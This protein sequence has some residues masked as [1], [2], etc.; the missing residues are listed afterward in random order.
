MKKIQLAFCTFAVALASV[1]SNAQNTWSPRAPMLV[2]VD[3]SASCVFNNQLY[4]FGGEYQAFGHLTSAG[5]SYDSSANAW[6]LLPP[7]PQVIAESGAATCQG[8]IYVV[9]GLAASGNNVTTVSIF[10][11]VSGAWSTGAPMPIAAAE[12]VCV[13]VNGQIYCIGNYV[14]GGPPDFNPTGGEVQI[15]DPTT[16]SWSIGPLM[17]TPRY[18]ACGVAVGSSIY[19]FGGTT[20]TVQNGA[21]LAIVE[22]LDTTT[23][24]WS[25]KSSL[26]VGETFGACAL[27]GGNIYVLGG[28][29]SD[30]APAVS[31]IVQIYDPQQDSWSIGQPLPLLL[32]T[33]QAGAVSSTGTTPDTIIIAG[34]YT[35]GTQPDGETLA[36][37][38]PLSPAT[39]TVTPNAVSTTYDGA[40][41]GNA[42]YSD[43]TG[44]YT[45]TGFQNGDTISSAGV[46]LSGSMAFN[47]STSTTVENVGSYALTAGTLT[48]SSANGNYVM[49]FSNP[50]GNAYVITPATLTVTANSL[51]KTYGSADPTLTYSVSGLQG[52][53]AASTVLMGSLART[54]GEDV[55][56]YA[57]NQGTLA[58]TP[59]ASTGSAETFYVANYYNNTIV[60]FDSAGNASLFASS[61]LNGPTGLAFDAQGNLYVA[62]YNQD[63]IEKFS[64]TGAD[65]GVFA[66]TLCCGAYGLAFDGLGNLYAGIYEGQGG[67]GIERFDSSGNA[68][69]FA[70]IEFPQGLA[71]DTQGNLYVANHVQNTIEKFSSTGVDLGAFAAAGMDGPEALAFDGRGNLYVANFDGDT[72]EKFDSA[73]NASLF[74]SSGLDSPI[75]LAFD[76]S[77]NLYVVNRDSDTIEKFSPTGTDLGVFAST[78][79]DG[80]YFIAI[81]QGALGGNANYAINFVPGTLT[82]TEVPLT[83][84][85]PANIV[86][87]TGGACSTANLPALNIGTP[88][89]T[90]NIPDVT[91]T[92]SRSDGQSLTAAYPVGIT[93][94]TW[95]VTDVDDGGY[96]ATYNQTVEVTDDSSISGNFNGTRIPEGSTIWFTAVLTPRLPRNVTAPVTIW[97]FAQNITSSAF[98]LAVPNATVVFDPAATSASANCDS[99]GRWTTRAPWSGLAGNT[100]LAT[101]AYQL[102]PG[103]PLPGGLQPVK[104][105]GTFATDTPGVT[106]QWQWSAAVYSRFG[107][108]SNA[109]VK[110]T[111]DPFGDWNYKNSDCAGTP[112]NYKLYVIGGGQGGGGLNCTGSL[113]SAKAVVPC[114]EQSAP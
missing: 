66:S 35:P 92:P 34:G 15:Y 97:F 101:Y 75:G 65:L 5:E 31:S 90:P 37:T 24:T 69:D 6:S 114:V 95:T 10:D 27:V 47:G 23:M 57:I 79:L 73:G 83:I 21:P 86:I 109:G 58:V 22:A 43:N 107:N 52:S 62:N 40:A 80:P 29:T 28:Q 8:K 89:W 42:N 33:F 3:F 17:L 103:Q 11:P 12:Y 25:T 9:G 18:G 44:N 55:G 1:N 91:V 99:S 48:L 4:V 104:W 85:W 110:C 77:G 64:P 113:G 98:N 38:V 20:P 7:L 61:G 70:T 72:V 39:L 74:A 105:D 108:C 45:I 112:E 84:T 59:N 100:L 32:S 26:P 94:I 60:T 102:P 88:T 111:D 87:S 68:S 2:P 56:T 41:L 14:N 53:D 71:F 76:S 30:S 96:S 36:F 49:N 78:S 93:T 81:N 19:V 50:S 82:I 63:T 106:L 51:T 16:D 13:P 46:T 67:I 54:P